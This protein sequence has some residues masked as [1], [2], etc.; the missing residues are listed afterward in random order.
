MGN[1]FLSGDFVTFLKVRHKVIGSHLLIYAIRKILVDDGED[2]P[3]LGDVCLGFLLADGG[4]NLT[5]DLFDGHHPEESFAFCHCCIDK[6][7]A[8]VGDEDMVAALVSL[9]AQGFHVVDLICFRCTV[10]RSHRLSA[11]SASRG[12]GDEMAVTLLL[13]DVVER[14]NNIRPARDVGVDGWTLYVVV[15]RGID[16]ARS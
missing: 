2:V 14:I 5:G 8:D 1:R 6:A 7:G 13:E 9:L 11:Q 16:V 4:D 12:N 15:Q 10:G 3:A